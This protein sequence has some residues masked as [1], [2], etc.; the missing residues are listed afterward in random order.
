[1]APQRTSMNATAAFLL[2]AALLPLVPAIAAK[3]GGRRYDNN[4]PRPWLAGQAGWRARANSA[5]ANTFEALPFF[6]AAVLYALH[7][8]A[9]AATLHVLMGAWLVAR[10]VYVALYIGGRGNLRSLIWLAA[11]L[12]N[13][14]I[15][16]AGS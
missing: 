13:V 15:L 6:F 12:V 3:A 5:Q 8:Q 7:S 2:A 11:L 4:D 9:P 16:L 14:A 1:M 10:L